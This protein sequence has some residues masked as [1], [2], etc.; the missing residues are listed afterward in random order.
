MLADNSHLMIFFIQ[1]VHIQKR[2]TL[3]SFISLTGFVYMRI[4]IHIYKHMNYWSKQQR[5]NMNSENHRCIITRETKPQIQKST[6]S[7]T[8]FIWYYGKGKTIGKKTNQCYP[9]LQIQGGI[10]S[11]V[12]Q[13]HILW[14]WKYLISWL[15]WWLYD[16]MHL[17]KCIVLYT[18]K[19]YCMH[20]KVLH[21]NI[22]VI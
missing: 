2:Y 12:A 6:Y 8:P 16:C 13:G 18:K 9:G 20:I 7:M 14:W 3:T 22:Y 1:S 10:Y 21:I 11:K 5:I 17:L 15:R 4:H 19:D